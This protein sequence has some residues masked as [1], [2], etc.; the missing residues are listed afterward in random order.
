MQAHDLKINRALVLTLWAT[1][2]AERL[3]FAPDE[4]L[5][6]GRAVA[7]LNAYAKGVALESREML[8][9]TAKLR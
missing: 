3:G 5:S 2:V 1:V 8:G 6:L 4:A 7:G 9:V